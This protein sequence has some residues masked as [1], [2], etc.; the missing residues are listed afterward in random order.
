LHVLKLDKSLNNLYNEDKS[1]DELY[2]LFVRDDKYRYFYCHAHRYESDELEDD[3][4]A[5]F[6]FSELPIIQ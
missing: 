3:P 6:H 2:R 5:S 1:L 4:K